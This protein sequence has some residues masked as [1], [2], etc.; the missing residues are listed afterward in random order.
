M[1]ELCALMKKQWKV[2]SMQNNKHLKAH[3][4][5][6]LSD[7]TVVPSVTTVIGNLNKPYLVKWANNLG[8]QGIDSTQYVNE[9]AKAGSLAHDMILCHLKGQ[10]PSTTAYSKPEIDMAETAFLK[11]LEWESGHKLETIFAETPFVSEHNRFGG[12]IDWFGIMDGVPTLLDF[13]TSKAVYTEHWLQV[14]AYLELL[15]EAGHQVDRVG[16]IQIDRRDD[17]TINAYEHIK[18][19]K[20]EK[21]AQVF[22]HLLGIHYLLKSIKGDVQ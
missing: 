5:Y 12:T 17:N 2:I 8:L 10:Q 19:A 9:Q 4:R 22:Y 18:D 13:K 15:R 20:L 21:E 16:I 14:A 3:T 1:R 6:K 7:G 11:F